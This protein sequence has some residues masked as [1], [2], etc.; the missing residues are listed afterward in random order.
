MPTEHRIAIFMRAAEILSKKMKFKLNAATMLGQGKTMWQAEIDSGAELI[1]FLRYNCLYATRLYGNQPPEH[2]AGVWNKVE[3]RPLEGFVVAVSPF[4]FTA[5][6]GNLCSMPALMGNVCLW[7][8]SRT[9]A[10]S[11]YICMKI[12][13]EA[14]LPA[15]VIQYVPTFQSKE[16]SEIVFGH[17]DFAGL[18]FTGSTET[19]QMFWKKIGEN[20]QNYKSYP[21][22]VGETGGKNFH[23][24]HKSGDVDSFCKNTV[25]GAFEYS[26]QKC[27]A[28]SR[29]YCPK[30]KW[31]QAKPILI[32]QTKKVKVGKPQDPTSYT[33]SVIDG[34]SWNKIKGFLERAK[35]DKDVEI[36][37]GGNCD[38]KEGW[39]VEPTIIVSKNPKSETMVH[40]IFGPVVTVFVYEDEKLEETLD[41]LDSTSQYALTGSVFCKC[42]YALE[43]I[44]QKLRHAAGNFYINDKSTGAVVGQQP[45]GGAR[46]SGTNDKA[47]AEYC[48]LRWCSMRAIKETFLPLENIGYPSIDM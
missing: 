36:I 28:T 12:F 20:I 37:A 41:L 40:E 19:F 1:D 17:P 10:L 2:S 22:I 21:R 44:C 34:A 38:D 47:G 46:A 7:K 30:S 8:P 35:A 29:I 13:Q 9:A 39:Y 27:S 14:G 45:F 16:F 31:E 42:R 26:G 43:H 25:R 6:G 32:E 11:N 5:I 18:H 15:G 4:N 24:L 48:L 23:L 3:Y 33:S